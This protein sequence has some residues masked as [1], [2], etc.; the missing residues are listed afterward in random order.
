MDFN[1]LRTFLEVAE[2]KSFSRAAEKLQMTQPAIS[3][4]I[5]S[6]E[7]ELGERLFERGGGKVSLTAAGKVFEPFAQDCLGKLQHIQL[8]IT[9]LQLAPRGT[10]T[11][12]ANESTA[13]HVL[14]SFFSRFR[15]LYPRV[16]LGIVRAERSQSIESVLKREADFGVV[17]TPVKDPRLRI[18]VI[19]KDELQLVVSPRNPLSL[20]SAVSLE[21]IAQQPLLLPK[22]GRRRDTLDKIFAE[23]SQPVRS[24][25]ELDSTEL[26][27][28]LII[29]ELGVG[30][31]PRINVA[32]EVRTGLLVALPITD[33]SLPR[34]LALI[35]LKDRKM[36][37]A[38]Q[39]FHQVV[40]GAPWPGPSPKLG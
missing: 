21:E 6:L 12:S 14:P 23:H 3:A 7:T 39:A 32:D 13:L 38:G 20:S 5:R 37:R 33:V 19:H 15:K 2:R 1:Y 36:T 26:L 34:D 29:A 25:M 8:A 31:L 27:K 4:Q 24:V 18:E 28:K 35:S 9:D 16:S 10:L 40:T 17:S 30:F 22:Q 11:V